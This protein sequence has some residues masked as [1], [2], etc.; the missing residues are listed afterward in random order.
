MKTF[1]KIAVSLLAAVLLMLT[2]CGG[3]ELPEGMDSDALFA[4]GRDV[5][6]LLVNGEYETVH[7]MLREDQRAL[8]TAE[9]IR[10]VVERE[11]DGAGVY[12]QIDDH[13]V[14][15]QMID[16][17]RYGIAVLDCDFSEEDV[18][19]RVSFDAQLQLVGFS[20]KQD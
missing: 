10:E 18:L 15:G 2:A 7:E 14:T 8:F 20:L 16:G 13:M 11:L 9:D 3:N 1:K 17:Q 19:V 5:M 4:A 12:K 6:L